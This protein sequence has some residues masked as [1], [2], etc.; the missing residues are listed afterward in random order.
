MGSSSYL[1]EGVGGRISV[2]RLLHLHLK[3]FV[4]VSF[5]ILILSKWRKK[6]NNQNLLRIG[7]Q[8]LRMG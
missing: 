4:L 3:S 2:D 5:L 1:N 8:G 7:K 6:K